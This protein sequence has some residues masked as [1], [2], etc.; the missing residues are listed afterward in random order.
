MNDMEK[1]IFTILTKEEVEA[2]RSS[3]WVYLA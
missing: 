3:A 1:I 2:D